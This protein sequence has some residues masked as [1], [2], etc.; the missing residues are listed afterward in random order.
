MRLRASSESD[1]EPRASL[2]KLAVLHKEGSRGA[3]SP[4]PEPAAADGCDLGALSEYGL[5]TPSSHRGLISNTLSVLGH[6]ESGASDHSSAGCASILRT[7]VAI[8][9]PVCAVCKLE[10]AVFVAVV[11]ARRA[12]WERHGWGPPQCIPSVIGELLRMSAF[13]PSFLLTGTCQRLIV[14]GEDGLRELA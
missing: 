14:A 2:A 10:A 7:V 6:S 9:I 13:I 11:T 12:V 4:V 5:R 8:R 1:C 3:T